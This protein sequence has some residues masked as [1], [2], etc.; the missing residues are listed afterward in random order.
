VEIAALKAE[1]SGLKAE[2]EALKATA[3]AAAEPAE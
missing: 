3:V 2:I 1:N